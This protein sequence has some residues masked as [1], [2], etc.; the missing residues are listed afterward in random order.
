M[1][2]CCRHP[3]GLRFIF[4]LLMGSSSSS[5]GWSQVPEQHTTGTC[6]TSPSVS[7][8]VIQASIIGTWSLEDEV[9]EYNYC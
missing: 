7:V 1:F 9:A 4:L 3:E 2:E 8:D 6:S 5:F